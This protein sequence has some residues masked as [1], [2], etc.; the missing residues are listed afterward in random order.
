MAALGYLA[1]LKRG[2]GLAFGT[3]L[4]HDFSLKMFLIW[5][6]INGQS[7]P[8]LFLSQ[9]IKQTGLLS[10]YFDI[11]NFKIFLGSTS[12][13]M[14]DR[15]KKREDENTKIWIP[16]ERKELFR[17]NK[18]HLSQ[19]LKGYHLVKNKNLIKNCGHKL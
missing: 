19:Y 3:H 13:A 8:T 7:C 5:Y 1:R 17:W 18:K 4:L 10:S 11:I 12:K 6:C 2:L 15:G 9:D 16:R 14:A